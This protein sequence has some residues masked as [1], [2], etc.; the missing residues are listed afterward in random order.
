MCFMKK[1]FYCCILASLFSVSTG[2]EEV[3][4][5]PDV[6][7]KTNG[8]INGHSTGSTYGI[9]AVFR[10]GEE[11]CSGTV[12]KDGWVL[13]ACHCVTV[14]NAESA[15]GAVEK[16]LSEIMIAPTSNYNPGVED[17][18]TGSHGITD[19]HLHP[20]FD[21][22]LLETPGIEAVYPYAVWQSPTANLEGT[23]VLA[24]GYGMNSWDGSG[25]GRLRFGWL[26]ASW[27]EQ[28][29]IR[30][31]TN[32]NGQQLYHG[33][34]GGPSFIW[35]HLS[36][37]EQYRYLV[38][39][40]QSITSDNSS[41]RGI[42]HGI[43]AISNWLQEK[44]GYLYIHRTVNYNR[45]GDETKYFDVKYNRNVNGTKVWLWHYSGS[46]AQQ[47]KY[48]TMN[49]KIF[50]K[51]GKCITI[52]N[53]YDSLYSQISIEDC[54]NKDSQRWYFKNDKTIRSTSGYC[55]TASGNNSGSSIYLDRC[56]GLEAQRWATAF[57]PPML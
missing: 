50:N 9:V 5:S 51:R 32:T 18:P 21:I 19:M 46:S 40:H 36:S 27:A 47:W 17:P 28:N 57:V 10:D 14:N 12:I 29:I 15:E 1:V 56:Q 25:R 33:D 35:G 11:P 55:L 54:V 23:N 49:K 30:Y 2:C 26:T 16:P 6:V 22:A 52:N 7:Q 53:D 39:V 43:Y 13:T 8:I 31:D 48:N 38:G 42:D 45:V 20:Y 3:E 41:G 44:M 24:F 34:S 4:Q 37:G